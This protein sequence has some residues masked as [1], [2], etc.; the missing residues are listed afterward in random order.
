VLDGV[1][2]EGKEYVSEEEQEEDEEEEGKGQLSPEEYERHRELF[3]QRFGK[4]PSD[5]EE[6]NDEEEEE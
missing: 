1:D 5:D 4:Y 2:Q 3:K 6:E